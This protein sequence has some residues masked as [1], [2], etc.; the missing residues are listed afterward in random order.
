I[1]QTKTE[2][3]SFFSV[4]LCVITQIFPQL[5][6]E[7]ITTVNLS[8]KNIFHYKIAFAR[9]FRKCKIMRFPET[10]NKYSLSV[11]RNNITCVQYSTV[12]GVAELIFKSPQD[13]LK[14]SSPVVTFQVLYIFQH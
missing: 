6:S 1:N 9:Q 2:T 11:L 8:F 4:L 13:Y 7:R 12:N 10:N 5:I 3:I 14:C